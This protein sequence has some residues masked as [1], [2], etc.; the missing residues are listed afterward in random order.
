MISWLVL[1]CDI[2]VVYKLAVIP[3]PYNDIILQT[4]RLIARLIF[5]LYYIVYYIITATIFILTIG[6]LIWNLWNKPKGI[7]LISSQECSSSVVECLTQERGD[8]GSSLTGV[9]SLCPWARHIN[10]SLILIQPRKT[11]PF[12]TEGLLMGCKESNKQTNK[13]LISCIYV[14]K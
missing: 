2:V 5:Y 11:R 8:V 7:L 12:I 1:S 9:N 14:K 6:H 4:W 3:L 10:P 13:S